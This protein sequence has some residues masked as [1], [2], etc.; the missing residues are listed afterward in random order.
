M[1][2]PQKQL[3]GFNVQG[4]QTWKITSFQKKSARKTKRIST[5]FLFFSRN[6]TEKKIKQWEKLTRTGGYH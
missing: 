6:N 5:Q 3:E 1:T 2:H 4:T